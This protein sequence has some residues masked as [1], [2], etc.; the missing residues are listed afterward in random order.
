MPKTSAKKLAWQAAYNA[1]P[2]RKE[3]G[4]ELRRARRQAIR[5]GKVAIGDDKDIAH[6]RAADNGGRGKGNLTVKPA[7]KN[8]GWRKSSGYRVPNE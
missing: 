5:E 4:V 8:R 1:R 2:E 6:K 7:S 3:I